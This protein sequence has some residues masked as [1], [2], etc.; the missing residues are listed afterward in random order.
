MSTMPPSNKNENKTTGTAAVGAPI[1]DEMSIGSQESISPRWITPEENKKKGEH[2]LHWAGVLRDDII[3]AENSTEENNK[4]LQMSRR[5]LKKP[6][7]K[8]GSSNNS[9]STPTSPGAAVAGVGS[10]TEDIP[11]VDWEFKTYAVQSQRR[12]VHAVKFFVYEKLPL[13]PGARAKLHGLQSQAFL[14]NESVRIIEY[15][16]KN[17]KYLIRPSIP[18][19]EAQKLAT[20]GM[21]I[22]DGKN[23]IA[24]E[25]DVLVWTF[26]ALYDGKKM[27]QNMA[28]QFI[29]KILLIVEGLKSM[30]YDLW[31]TGNEMSCQ[32]Q[33]G[34]ILEA[35]MEHFSSVNDDNALDSTLEYCKTVVQNNLKIVLGQANAST[36]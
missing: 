32:E 4:I 17:G 6:T 7:P 18:L 35:Q 27:T 20:T 21:L 30:E 24:P 33:F 28:C 16:Q 1:K 34:P 31:H 25:Q 2:I 8:N 3:L 22:V 29:E 15:N 19:P 23:L 11:K 13:K 9:T 10:N 5:F 14:N 26:G 12:M 36:M